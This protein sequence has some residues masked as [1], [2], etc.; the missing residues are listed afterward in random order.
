MLNL[1]SP[2]TELEFVESN[3]MLLILLTIL[4]LLE[5]DIN[6]YKLILDIYLYK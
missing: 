4:E 2:E 6:T 3:N 5:N 1:P